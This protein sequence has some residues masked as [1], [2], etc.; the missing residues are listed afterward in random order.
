M[1]RKRHC[2][3]IKGK[4]DNYWCF[5]TVLYNNIHNAT[6]LHI[7]YIGTRCRYFCLKLCDT[8]VAGSLYLRWCNR[9][10]IH[11]K[12]A[13]VHLT[14]SSS[15]SEFR[16]DRKVKARWGA[17]EITILFSLSV[18]CERLVGWLYFNSIV[19]QPRAEKVSI[20]ERKERGQLFEASRFPSYCQE[21]GESGL[22]DDGIS[23]RETCH[24][25]FQ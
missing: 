20:G 18:S 2:F 22:L 8:Y 19:H 3:S 5:Q 17:T 11:D 4:L 21:E 16:L 23:Q 25:R 24:T 14:D 6:L 1:K 7:F 9:I 12:P 15:V 10:E 13:T